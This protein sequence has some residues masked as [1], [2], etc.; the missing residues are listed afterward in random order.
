MYE[1]LKKILKKNE[2]EIKKVCLKANFK[3]ILKT[4]FNS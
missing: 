4:L 1:I 3:L 2:L